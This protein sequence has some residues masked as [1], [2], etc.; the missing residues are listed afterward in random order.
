MT[1]G[2][3]KLRNSAVG[4]VLFAVLL[5]L[6]HS[7]RLQAQQDYFVTVSTLKCRSLAMGAAAMAVADD[8][9]ALS[10][11]PAA[12]ELY[13]A[14]KAFRLTLLFN[15][16]SPVVALARGRDLRGATGSKIG[17][18]ALATATLLKGA[19]VTISPFELLLT[20]GEETPGFGPRRHGPEGFQLR[21]Y[22]D[23]F[24]SSMGVKV[25]LASQVALG[26]GTDVWHLSREHSQLWQ[27]G[28]SYG[29]LIRPDPRLS[30]GLVYTELPD[31]L[32]HARQTLERIG[33]ES[34][35]LGL[36]W[37]PFPTTV[38]SAD[39]RHI[40]EE[41]DPLTRELHLGAEQVVFRHLAVRGG[42]YR[43]RDNRRF[44]YSFGVGLLD[45][46]AF[47]GSE[48]QFTHPTFIL[49]YALVYRE[50]ADGP[51]RWHLLSMLFRL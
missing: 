3:T 31:S 9:G 4:V 47:V 45:L 28:F 27:W 50:M 11:N 12:V 30:V 17:D 39:L 18:V 21:N 33:D 37:R 6:A 42:V 26:V 38:L 25:R 14:P 32:N 43:E 44:T 16:V 19:A 46:N 29:V 36:A 49:N 48:R 40:G 1:A 8:F 22:L 10:M 5:V 41:G 51:E 23:A 2:G 24:S 15:P 7:Q 34:L 13:A 35:N 20:W